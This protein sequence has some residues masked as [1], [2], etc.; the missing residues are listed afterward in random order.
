M[1]KEG[2]SRRAVVATAL[3]PLSAVKIAAAAT[4]P[5]FSPS[6]RRTLE[7]FLDRLVP[8][9]ENGPSA[10]DC[11][12]AVYIER[13]LADYLAA[14]KTSLLAGLDA[15]ESYARS[16]HGN[17]FAALAADQQ[18][19]VLRAIESNNV[20]TFANSGAFFDRVRRLAIEGM[21]SD[22]HYGGNL[23]Y[24]G[25]NLIRYPGPRLAVA[26]SEQA[27]RNTIKPVRISAYG[28]GHGN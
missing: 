15:V 28:S 6:Q 16:A 7:A 27:M 25:W 1:S 22:P 20:N 13:S 12:V 3:V 17:A 11:G 9:D 14:E 21:M 24:A 2:I 19:A 23:N 5:V 8:R 10:T 26:E 4:A 18:D